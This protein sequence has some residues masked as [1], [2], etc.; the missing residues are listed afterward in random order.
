MDM[1]TAAPL[2]TQLGEVLRLPAD[3]LGERLSSHASAERSGSP[4]PRDGTQSIASTQLRGLRCNPLFG[5]GRA[6][7]RQAAMCLASE[8]E[9]GAP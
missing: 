9:P 7:H 1:Y 8:R 4:G 2:G 3:Q 5:R 6:K